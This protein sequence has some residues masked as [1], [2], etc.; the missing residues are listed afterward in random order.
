MQ[1]IDQLWRADNQATRATSQ[2][3][4]VSATPNQVRRAVRATIPRVGLELEGAAPAGSEA[5]GHHLFKGAARSWSPSVQKAEEARVRQV[6]VEVIGPAASGL[7]IRPGDEVLTVTV[8]WVPATRGATRVNVDFKSD[9]PGADCSQPGSCIKEMPPAALRAAYYE[10]WTA[11][12]RELA[13]IGAEDAAAAREHRRPAAAR[14][15][16]SK[17]PSAWTPP[18]SGWRP[19]PP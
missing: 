4:T 14:R 2:A 8:V 13:E 3:R 18:P 7:Q 12:D 15:P 10:F 19:P 17:P 11:F 9:E 6:F 16:A 5:R 1:R